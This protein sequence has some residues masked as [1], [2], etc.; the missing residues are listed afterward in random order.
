MQRVCLR[1]IDIDDKTFMLRL[2]NDPDV[3]K[4][5]PRLISDET[6]MK[7]WIESLDDTDHEYIIEAADTRTSIGECSLTIKG[8]TAEVGLMILPDYWNQGAGSET[9]RKLLKIAETLTAET[10]T[11]FTDQNNRA[12][13]R[14]L[15]KNGFSFSKIGW[16]I[17]F[18]DRKS[19]V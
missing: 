19:V 4:F 8:K 14:I 15:E 17:K 7:A 16:M 5:L 2:A 11:A 1:S 10:A 9:I 13:I 3:S 12:L 6:M 18:A